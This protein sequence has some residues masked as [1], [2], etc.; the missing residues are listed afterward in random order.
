MSISSLF[1]SGSGG[2]APDSANQELKFKPE[3]EFVLCRDRNGVAVAVYKGMIWDFNPYRLG[4]TRVNRFRFDTLFDTI[5]PRE[6]ALVDELKYIVYCL[7]Y[8]AGNGR[9]GRLSVKTL[10][11]RWHVL[12]HAA[13]FCLAQKNKPLVGALS[14]KQLLGTQAYLEAFVA[15]EVNV[16]RP[17]MLSSL[18]ANLISVGQDRLG[19]RVVSSRDLNLRR[20]RT[21]QH[22]VIPT[23][24]YL[25][26]INV[27]QDLL[28]QIYDGVDNVEGFLAAFEDEFYGLMYK[29]QSRVQGKLVRELST[30]RSPTMEEALQTHGLEKVFSGEFLCTRKRGISPTI[31]KMQYVVKSII[32]LYTGMRDQEV[33]RM[34]Y[35][36]LS[37]ELFQMEVVDDHGVVRDA[38]KT[39]MVLSTTTKFKGYKEGESWFAPREVV[40]AI[41][42][43]QAICRGLAHLYKV[44]V[45]IGCPL[46]LSP[47][48]LRLDESEIG[49]GKL[50]SHY[51][52]VSAVSDITIQSSDLLEL[53]QTDR[54][55]DF[56]NDHG[57]AIGKPWPLTSHQFR[58]SLAF[59]GTNSGFISLP[60]LKS[61]Y[62]QMTL[63]M[64]RYYSN[65]FKDLRTIFGYYDPV[66]KE[67]VLPDSHVALEF[68]M[69]MPMAVANQLL[70]DVLFR[71]APLFG[72]TGSYM[73]K[74][75]SRIQNEEVLVEDVRADTLSRVKNGEISY[76]PTLLGGC[77]KVGRCNFF[78]LG[79]F[80]ECL[81]C[82]SAIIKPE[83][84]MLVIDDLNVELSS[85]ADDTG[86]Y[87]ITKNDIER[88]VNF[89]H[90]FADVKRS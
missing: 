5:G 67:F 8:Y 68:Q 64:A 24:I 74:Q 19:Y 2:V 28:D 1:P 40:K 86:E 70:S 45:K 84:V 77:S 75:K 7:I 16:H 29:V 15:D 17:Q 82:E 53:V 12:R 61:Q 44:D 72:G 55:R 23:R 54:F 41:K 3:E 30:T 47:T 43:A 38:A 89:S 69:G 62:K 18:L 4:A 60:T 63:E 37:E 42:V 56:Y 85:F 78:L 25:E 26:L 31:L 81:S 14:L 9:L 58:R 27:L 76:R 21:N 6:N 32:H 34:E 59:Y 73:E 39:V 50:A 80:V 46:F 36:C 22:P 11:Q 90:R 83:K 10:E 52:K 49:V 71:E 88:L 51:A 48:I 35:N 33:L 87:Q 20:H 57:F 66:S 65:G 79:E 13:V